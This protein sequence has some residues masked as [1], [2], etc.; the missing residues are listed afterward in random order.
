MVLM[1][2]QPADGA[3][4]VLAVAR[5]LIAA[6]SG[7]FLTN[8]HHKND[9]FAVAT[10]CIVLINKAEKVLLLIDGNFASNGC[11]KRPRPL[12]WYLL[13]GIYCEITL[14]LF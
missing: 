10:V 5:S 6:A 11:R 8:R 7:F 13:L 2:F 3:I 1:S 4:V 14:F 9:S 12:A